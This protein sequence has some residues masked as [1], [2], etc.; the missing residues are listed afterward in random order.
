VYVTIYGKNGDT[1]KRFL[2]KEK[3]F[4]RNQ[5]D[6]FGVESVDLGELTKIRVGVSIAFVI[7]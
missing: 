2:E 6:D 3:A 4:Q 5:T 7:D 1:G